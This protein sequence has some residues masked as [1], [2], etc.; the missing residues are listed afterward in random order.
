[1]V[2]LKVVPKPEEVKFNPQTKTLDRTAAENVLNPPDKSALEIALEL[3][4]AHGGT[5]TVVSMGPPFA[6]DLLRLCLGMGADRALLASDRRFAGADTYP[7]SLV[8]ARLVQRAGP[9]DLVLCGDESA[10]AATGQV[11]AGVAEWLNVPQIT[12]VDQLRIHQGWFLARRNLGPVTETVGVPPPALVAVVS[13]ANQPRFPNFPRMDAAPEDRV[14]VLSADD[15]GLGESDVGLKG[16]Y[17]TVDGLIAG[18]T[19]ERKRQR[20]EGTPAEQAR[21]VAEAMRP[22]LHR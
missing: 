16:S 20:V 21:I 4:D 3:R 8:L 14:R 17:T 2:C 13:G 22:F 18:D 11:P 10:D 5:V 15:L 7:T 9:H 6:K 1:M 12:F 19:V